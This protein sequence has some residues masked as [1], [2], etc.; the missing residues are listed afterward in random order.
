MM[1]YANNH[2]SILMTSVIRSPGLLLPILLL[3][4]TA[5][6]QDMAAASKGRCLEHYRTESGN[7]TKYVPCPAEQPG[8]P[9][10]QHNQWRVWDA[11]RTN[12]SL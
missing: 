7:Q 2:R 5:C 11:G 3:V 1:S 10:L 9:W 6:A 8:A 12:T 4:L